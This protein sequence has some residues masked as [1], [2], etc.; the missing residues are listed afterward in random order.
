[1]S[2]Q[3]YTFKKEHIEKLFRG[4]LISEKTA[5]MHGY[6]DGGVIPAELPM[7]PIPGSTPDA[8]LDFRNIELPETAPPVAE[9]EPG[10]V[11]QLR[12]QAPK[13]PDIAGAMAKSF[14]AAEAEAVGST[15]GNM[16]A[17]LMEGGVDLA[18][19]GPRAAEAPI[20]MPNIPNPMDQGFKL[21]QMAAA[22]E[23]GY[24][25]ALEQEAATIQQQ[26]QKDQE[27]ADTVLKQGRLY[28]DQALAATP[29]PD[30]IRQ[31][32]WD[33]KSTGQKM[34]AGIGLVLGA[35][36]PDGVNRAVQ[37]MQGQ[38]DQNIKAQEQKAERLGRMSEQQNTLY[39]QL[40]QKGLDKMQASLAMKDL[41]YKD[42]SMQLQK[43]AQNTTNAVAKANI[44]KAVMD[45]E[46]SRM[47]LGQEYVSRKQQER[48]LMGGD[49]G[50]MQQRFA[51][52]RATVP[53]ELQG[54]AIKELGKY[55]AIQSSL[56][57]LDAVMD[58]FDKLQ[59]VKNR[60]GNPIQSDSLLETAEADLFPI[61][62]AVV[63]EKMTDADAR[64]LIKP[65]LPKLLDSAE[66]KAQKKENLKSALK[67][68]IAGNTPILS[69][70][71]LIQ[72]QKSL[73]APGKRGR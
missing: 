56:G 14:P 23:I 52:L 54:E 3:K 19:N 1:M 11:S 60:A 40:R 13:G 59:T 27:E 9:G 2:K 5:K 47:R 15:G 39:S 37:I 12:D 10:W 68:N 73:P 8:A 24:G 42:V 45:I 36:S 48:A 4:G 25:K 7:T 51:K 62:K 61:V 29:N 58:R 30:Q 21:G 43:Q 70:Y 32:F 38:I 33:D 34:L 31:K 64:I 63:G 57:Q 72:E 46:E 35:F 53:K 22:G 67:A 41:M 6:A 28:A 65:Y 66:T 71:G 26:F 20:E 55:D 49:S 16:Q 69:G 44:A 18:G 50:G 17:G